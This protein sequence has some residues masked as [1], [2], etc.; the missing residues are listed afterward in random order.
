M[1]AFEKGPLQVKNHRYSKDFE[2]E[3]WRFESFRARQR[4][5]EDNEHPREIVS[6]PGLL[7]LVSLA[8]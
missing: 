4:R 2:P 1:I 3:G 6:M 7:S 8:T 5:Y